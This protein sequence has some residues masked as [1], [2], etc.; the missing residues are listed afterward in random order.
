M[1]L[2]HTTGKTWYIV[3]YQHTMYVISLSNI[4][5]KKKIYNKITRVELK[6]T[7]LDTTLRETTFCAWRHVICYRSFTNITL[8][9]NHFRVTVQSSDNALKKKKV[10]LKIA[11][12]IETM[13]LEMKIWTLNSCFV[14]VAY[15]GVF[16]PAFQWYDVT[17]K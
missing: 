12:N 4:S 11:G 14:Y 8:L 15:I 3:L 7:N 2:V 13:S 5:I 10:D 6:L 16:F 1:W 17:T 9:F